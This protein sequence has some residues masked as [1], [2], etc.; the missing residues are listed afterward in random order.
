[1]S[2]TIS[3][4]LVYLW[5]GRGQGDSDHGGTPTYTVGWYLT[6]IEAIEAVKTSGSWGSPGKVNMVQVLKE[7]HADGSS[8]YY[9]I[10]HIEVS[11]VDM[12]KARERALAKLTPAEKQLLGLS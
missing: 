10:R 2:E 8:S 12:N 7:D 4:T 11:S 9:E 6:Q 3:G 5:E 1:M